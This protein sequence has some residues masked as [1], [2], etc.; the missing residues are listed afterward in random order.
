MYLSIKLKC[1]HTWCNVFSVH[2]DGRT[3]KVM[4]RGRF[5]PN[6]CTLATYIFNPQAHH[7]APAQLLINQDQQFYPDFPMLWPEFGPMGI[8][9]PFSRNVFVC[10][11]YLCPIWTYVVRVLCHLSPWLIERADAWAE[12]K[13][14]WMCDFW[15]LMSVRLL[16]G[17][18]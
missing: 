3:C 12:R 14:Y 7:P 2:T 13:I 4:Y 17:W 8:R 9:P 1:R 11:A 16:V 15:T 18:S 5:A 10:G 6:N